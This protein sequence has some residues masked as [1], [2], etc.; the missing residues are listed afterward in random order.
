MKTLHIPQHLLFDGTIPGEAATTALEKLEIAEKQLSPW[1]QMRLGKI[2][3]SQFNR[4]TRGQGGRGW[5]QG[6][7]SYL[8]ELLFEWITGEEA[9]QFSGND[10]TRW[11]EFY[12]NEAI[13][14][15]EK[16]TGR[17]VKRGKFYQAPAKHGFRGLVGC[18]PDGIGER[19]LEIKCPYGPK[20]HINTLL[21]GEVPEEYRD[22][23]HGHMLCADREICD[24]V[25]YD[26]R[27]EKRPD[28]MMTM[29]EVF[30][31]EFYMEDLIGRLYDFETTLIKAL[32]KLEIDWRTTIKEQSK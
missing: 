4:V 2:T 8:A 9:Q 12:E 22:Q 1:R 26:P 19:G 3:G 25:S 16:K 21:S 7:Q 10:A 17:K 27:F 13:A 31:D 5:S 30:R 11:G 24:F 14:A 29:V 23:V 15:Y 6:A 20:A 32:D 28:M 18:T